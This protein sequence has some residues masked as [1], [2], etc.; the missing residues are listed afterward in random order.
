[1]AASTLLSGCA[2][3]GPGE[4]PRKVHGKLVP[5]RYVS[6][7]AYAAYTEGAAAE[8]RNDLSRAERAYLSAARLDDESA[9]VWTRVGA[10]RCRRG[11]G[12]GA[13]AAFARARSID[14]GYSRVLVEEARCRLRDGATAEALSLAR[15]AFED[16]PSSSER[17]LFLAEVLEAA[18]DRPAAEVL[19]RNIA[20]RDPGSLEIAPSLELG[21]E[22]AAVRVPENVSSGKQRKPDLRDLDHAI[23]QRDVE[24]S[25]RL[26]RV[27]RLSPE[28][29][30]LRAVALGQAPLARDLAILVLDADGSR[31]DAR[32]ALLAA[33][34]LLDDP[35]AFAR[36]LVE[37]PP[38][39]LPPTPLGALLLTEVLARRI[40]RDAAETALRLVPPG[41]DDPLIRTVRE[42]VAR[43]LAA[44]SVGRS[45]KGTEGP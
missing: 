23:G 1:M 37:L 20:V 14:P 38:K 22:G 41:D 15:R 40:G 16:E 25:R 24:E 31:T 5:G 8:A 7:A 3:F 10:V 39:A 36:A 18:G 17:A 45:G 26:G 27:L 11:E 33:G 9:D 19:R 2:L 44:P 13:Q 43:T 12:P 32:I 35:A 4:V 30:A 29:L 6:E 21:P 28:A 34:D 42:R